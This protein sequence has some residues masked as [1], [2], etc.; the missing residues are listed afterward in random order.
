M[1]TAALCAERLM[2]Q[3]GKSAEWWILPLHP[4]VGGTSI[5]IGFVL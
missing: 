1:C 2:Q 3:G 5:K 4:P